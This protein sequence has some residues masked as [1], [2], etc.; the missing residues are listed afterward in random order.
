[1]VWLLY[2]L[3]L[4]S[5]LTTAAP[6]DRSQYVLGPAN[7]STA[8]TSRKLQGKFLHITDIHPDPFYRE[9]SDPAGEHPC[10][11]GEGNAGYF[12]AEKTQCDTPF[13]LIN[14]TFDWIKENVRDDIDF[15]VWTGDSARHDNDR[16]YPRTVQQV[17]Q[18]NEFVVQKFLE[19]FGKN[20][21]DGDHNSRNDLLIP[22]VPTFGN[23][24]ILPHNI[25]PPGPNK[26]TKKFLT[27]WR[28]FVPE[29]QRHSFAR[30][31]WFFTEVI[32]NKLAVFSLNTL[33]F[34]DSNSAVDG[35]SD[36]S[37]PGYEHF[38]WLRIQLELL[39]KRNMKAILTGHVPPARTEGKSSWDET[40]YQKYTLWLR[41]YRDV[42]VGNLY[43]HMNIDH[44]M[45]QDTRELRFP[46]PIDG[47]DRTE[48]L[49][50]FLDVND[51]FH[52]ST[53]SD[54][55][56]D[57]RATWSNLPAP[58]QGLS[59]M[60]SNNGTMKTQ[61]KKQKLK[62]FLKGIGGPFAERFSLSLVSPSVVPNFYP[63][64]RIIE[65]N[66]TGLDHAHPA[67][68]LTTST[69][70][71]S[72]SEDLPHTSPESW[73]HI[74][75]FEEDLNSSTD[76][77][78]EK[79][80]KKKHKH[81]KPKSKPNFPVPKP[82]SRSAPP[83]PAYSSQTFTFL[84][85]TQLY[86][87]LTEI[88]A[89]VQTEI[90]HQQSLAESDIRGELHKGRLRQHFKYEVEYTTGEE[91]YKMNDLTVRSWVDLAEKIGRTKF[92]PRRDFDSL[93]DSRQI[94]ETS[95]NDDESDQCSDEEA[96]E[97]ELKV[98]DVE[99][100]ACRRKKHGKKRKGQVLK[101]NELWHMFLRRAY[102]GTK[103]DSELEDEYG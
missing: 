53:K 41:Q 78:I 95:E 6:S 23:N 86:A 88:N 18:L 17:E 74:D 64:L 24:D 4:L 13:T 102:V 26:W 38:E 98:V 63:S 62:K 19:V 83:G 54:Y 66:I 68:L 79:A 36:P 29:E 97:C 69:D 1:M 27:I 85:W 32:P 76:P 14:A 44:F 46:F 21:H 16:K 37:E 99:A 48:I 20:G 28:N 103:P 84:S 11:R 5:A 31:G 39:R 90:S 25:F 56:C 43:G 87:N 72:N 47:I 77:A 35:C 52:I 100:Q 92:N 22:I 89:A 45:L 82:P 50:D 51:D 60:S 7:E 3:L 80:K 33:Y 15:V 75:E 81:K 65:Y 57:L 42:I 49:D 101:Q 67:S 9:G 40:C 58:P 30:G 73:L 96:Y 2:S 10:H 8:R 93:A 12:G 61:K 91:P 70:A 71:E 59:Y 55:L 34:F 94:I